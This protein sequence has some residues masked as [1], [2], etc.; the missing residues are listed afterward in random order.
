MAFRFKWERITKADA[1]RL[2]R[3]CNLSPMEQKILE[4]RR[5]GTHIEIIAYEIG[6]CRNR[7]I[8]Y[9]RILLDKI[10]AEL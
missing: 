3:V 8:Y 4:M 7:T 2:T 5:K 6:Y 10:Q 1:E 9:S